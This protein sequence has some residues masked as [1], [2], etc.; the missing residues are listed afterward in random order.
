MHAVEAVGWMIGLAALPVA[1]SY[2]APISL[3]AWLAYVAYN[4]LAN[5]AGHANVEVVAPGF[6]LRTRALFAAVFTYHCL[7]HARWTG[8]YGF[9][10]AW[11]DRVFKSEWDDWPA[12]HARV[13]A[14]QPL[15]SLKE[16]A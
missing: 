15:R 2:V 14:K 8:H 6:G 11:T 7:H 3:W 9:T 10:C 13:W 16:R 5:Q 4:V 1:L 12:L